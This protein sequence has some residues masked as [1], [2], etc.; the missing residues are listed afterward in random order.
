[1]NVSLTDFAS[2]VYGYSARQDFGDELSRGFF[3]T[4]TT[5]QRVAKSSPN[6]HSLPRHAG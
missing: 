5:C 6:N 1:M 2:V 4:S 3:E